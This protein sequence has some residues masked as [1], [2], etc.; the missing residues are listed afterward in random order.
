[1]PD[2]VIHLDEK[3][4]SEM[5][6]CAAALLPARRALTSEWT[7]RF[8]DRFPAP[9]EAAL[10][11][12][13]SR[14]NIERFL[15]HLRRGDFDG[16]YTA[17][18]EFGKSLAREHTPFGK[19]AFAI[20]L[21][22]LVIWDHMR[23][24][25]PNVR[26]RRR[27]REALNHLYYNGM[28]RLA[29]AY[30]VTLLQR[31]TRQRQR[32]QRLEK[33]FRTQAITDSLTGLYNRRHL[34]H[35]LEVETKRAQRYGRPLAVLVVD[36]DQFKHVNDRFGH[37]AG[38]RVLRAV[39]DAFRAGVRDTDIVARYG[40]DEFVLVLP[41]TGTRGARDLA[42][43]LAQR[44]RTI[45]GDLELPMKIGFSVGISVALKRYDRLLERADRR[46]YLHKERGA[47]R[48]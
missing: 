26:R 28:V 46:M 25:I 24:C 29:C 47:G 35:L 19:V 9:E 16:Y 32:L 5:A 36:L 22:E 27:L 43:R 44:V 48:A 42:D 10:A 37:A 18:E 40:G 20:H 31:I 11:A 7:S 13:L 33:Q 39:A 30:Y 2:E 4:Q 41:E 38:D 3:A 6:E 15:S 17:L 8:R 45:A 23:E 21:N 1:M 34:E 12:R 14:L